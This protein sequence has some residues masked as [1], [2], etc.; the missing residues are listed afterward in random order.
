MRGGFHILRTTWS[1]RLQSCAHASPR[2]TQFHGVPGRPAPRGTLPGNCTP[3]PPGRGSRRCRVQGILLVLRTSGGEG[4]EVKEAL[5]GDNQPLLRLGCN[6]KRRERSLSWLKSAENRAVGERMNLF[7]RVR[8]ERFRRSGS[9]R[10]PCQT[11]QLVVLAQERG[12]NIRHPARKAG[13]GS[14]LRELFWRPRD[15]CWQDVYDAVGEG[16]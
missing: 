12:P 16:R 4:R 11:R 6:K 8:S 10:G 1:S 13:G 5:K 15:L 3:P 2:R 14:I 7:W 9:W